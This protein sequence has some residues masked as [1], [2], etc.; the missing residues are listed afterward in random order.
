MNLRLWSLM[1]ATSVGCQDSSLKVFSAD[2]SA[3]ILTFADDSEVYESPR[4]EVLGKVNDDDHEASELTVRWYQDGE[5]LCEGPVEDPGGYTSC[6][7]ALELGYTTIVLEVTDP[8]GNSGSDAASVRVVASTPPEVNLVS[9]FNGDRHMVGE[10]IT[11]SVLAID[12]EDGAAL[13]AWLES[14]I[15][16]RLD[17]TL[18]LDAY[19]EFSVVGTL[20]E[21]EHEI[22]LIAEDST[23]KRAEDTHTVEVMPLNAPPEVSGL[24]ISPDPAFVT[25]PLLC[26]YAL[27]TDPDDD[28]D[29][30]TFTWFLEGVEIGTGPS[31][32]EGYSRDDMVVCVV[33][34]FDGTEYGTSIETAVTIQNSPPA[35]DAVE[36]IPE[37]VRRD[38]TLS[39]TWTGFGDPDGD[40]DESTVEWTVDGVDVGSDPEIV[41]DAERGDVVSC[42]VTP[43]DETD[44]GEAKSTSVM[45]GNSPPEVVSAAVVPDL[46][47]TNDEVAVEYATADLDGDSV[48]VA[49]QWLVNGEPL[50]EGTTLSGTEYFEKG[51][52]ISAVLIPDDGFEEG[53]AFETAAIIVQNT[54]PTAPVVT[55][56]GSAEVDTS[57]GISVAV[58]GDW[59][60]PFPAYPDWD[61]TDVWFGLGSTAEGMSGSGSEWSDLTIFDHVGEIIDEDAMT[62]LS[63]FEWAGGATGS[64]ASTGTS[65]VSTSDWAFLAR[66]SHAYDLTHGLEV[67]VDTWWEDTS[68]FTFWFTTEPGVVD[69]GSGGYGT[70]SVRL[71]VSFSHNTYAGGS[72]PSRLTVRWMPEGASDW[73]SESVTTHHEDVDIP[74]ARSGW[75]TLR[76]AYE[77]CG[78][79][80]EELV[81]E[82]VDPSDDADGDEVEYDFSWTREGA[83]FDDVSDLTHVG[84]RVSSTHVGYLE[85]WQCVATPFDGEDDGDA[86]VAD[87][88]TAAETL[89]VSGEETFSSTTLSAGREVQGGAIADIDGDGHMDAAFNEQLDNRIRIFWGD[90]SGVFDASATT[91]VPIGRSGASGDIEDINGDGHMDLVWGSQDSGQLWVVLGAGARSFLPSSSYSHP[92]GPNRVKLVDLNLD[93]DMDALVRDRFGSCVRRRLGN[94]DGT[95]GAA[96]CLIS[97]NGSV[98]A[99][100]VDGDGMTEIIMVNA[101]ELTKY[102]LDSSGDVVGSSPIDH[103]PLDGAGMPHLVDLDGDEDLDILMVRSGNLAVYR[104]DGEGNFEGCMYAEGLEHSPVAFG[105]LDSDDLIDFVSFD[106][107]S[108]CGSDV[109]FSVHD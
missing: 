94:G 78:V 88:L 71:R 5:V 2:P 15:Q 4:V 42:T 96:T 20:D 67:E 25:T 10:D 54:P 21:G 36:I 46:V 106:T 98:E 77:P 64:V 41:L 91:L 80:V 27:Y 56:T 66:T 99:A 14:S 17:L 16:G 18:A 47:F 6:D 85:E 23:G 107:C 75:H 12:A 9:P 89:C 52:A 101:S 74:A 31:L 84:D 73:S 87:Y 33:Y 57:C 100:D 50:A 70:D 40:P 26:S 104:N 24:E 38:S 32:T 63:D 108:F 48:S 105:Y 76:V 86:G 3:A 49:I 44:T 22:S 90:G 34:P 13:S 60:G 83:P 95:F 93:G 29:L 59:F 30:S 68:N 8:S 35:I 53:E 72:G 81:C 109:F 39:C 1:A 7:M 61:P 69:P 62:T 58:D 92:G 37:D 55:I 97:T 102:E 51:D 45:V 28:P 65:V 103:W 79:G 19:G 43:F 82:V 11:F